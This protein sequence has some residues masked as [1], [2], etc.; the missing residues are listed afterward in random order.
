MMQ[1]KCFEGIL[2]I[3]DSLEASRD[4]SMATHD[5]YRDDVTQS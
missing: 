1:D 5:C 2:I 4:R 3:S